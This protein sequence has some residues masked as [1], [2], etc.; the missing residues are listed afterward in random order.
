[1]VAVL[2]APGDL[3]PAVLA[4]V[5]RLLPEFRVET[6]ASDNGMDPCLIWMAGVSWDGIAGTDRQMAV[7]M[8]KHARLL[9]VD[10]PVSPMTT[11]A[12]QYGAARGIRPVLAEAAAG[13][14]RLTPVAPPGL[15]RP[16][17]R[18]ITPALVR[19][20]VRWA[21][22]RLGIR[23]SGVVMTFLGDLLGGWGDGVVNV[24]YGTDDYVAGAEL[25]GL[26]VNH[27]L[28]RERRAVAHADVVA[29]IT[30]E[31]AR[32]WS[33]LGA[34]PVVIRN[35]CWPASGVAPDPSPDVTDLP[36]PVVGLIGQLSDRIDIG[37]L[38]AIAD[39][40]YSLLLVGPRN[41]HWEPQRF[42]KL[43]SIPSV[44]Y[45][46]AV[47]SEAVPSYLAA[48]DVG[49]TPYQDTPFNRAS[50]P[51]KTLEYLAAGLP[52][53]TADLPAARWLSADLAATVPADAAAET[54]A[55]AS[56]RDDYTQAIASMT[57]S[58]RDSLAPFR[59]GFA[60][61]HSWPRRAEALASAIGLLPAHA[62][63]DSD[64]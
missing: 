58:G 35:G 28:D 17:V 33:G 42:A 6:S 54:L 62:T 45:V 15:S 52:V 53:V 11:A 21:V 13:I 24:L 64:R 39:A 14:T 25:M 31:L 38:E 30:P 50:F 22:G 10:P 29:V 23:P 51:L 63:A 60:A 8:T 1:M 49:I 59:V 16:G 44:R 2:E 12:R 26:P 56:S 18:A 34:R 55:L 7:A 27:L 20:Q 43:I 32:R 48:I 3:M 36:K 57:V 40:G 61:R 5:T 9:W 41:L 46:G 37:I 19:A 47:P 4:S